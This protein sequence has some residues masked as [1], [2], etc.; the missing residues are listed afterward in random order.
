MRKTIIAASALALLAGGAVAASGQN[1]GELLLPRIHAV[2]AEA[3]TLTAGGGDFYPVMNVLDG[4]HTD[5]ANTLITN[6]AGEVFPVVN[7]DGVDYVEGN[8][9]YKDTY[10]ISS[11]GSPSSMPIPLMLQGPMN[12]GHVNFASGSF[13]IDSNDKLILN[14]MANE[15]AKTGLKGIYM[16]G[17]ADSVGSYEG[18]LLISEKRV[19]AA[20]QYLE[21]KLNS[22]GVT[23]FSIRTEYMGDLVS[24]SKADPEDRRVEVMLYPII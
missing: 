16:V 7:K 18:N 17:K 20:M 1:N 8:L 9:N 6:A 22:I 15:I 3:H 13:A 4:S 5:P 10:F 24:K 2:L 12:I 11:P 14:A 23:D 21:N 19:N